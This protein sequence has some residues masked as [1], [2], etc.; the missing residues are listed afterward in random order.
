MPRNA[1]NAHEELELVEMEEQI[2]EGLDASLFSA[3]KRPFHM[4]LMEDVQ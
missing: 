3:T 1:G 4:T 2:S